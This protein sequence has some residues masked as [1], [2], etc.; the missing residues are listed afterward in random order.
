[1]TGPCPPRRRQVPAVGRI[2]RGAVE[3][4]Q[5]VA[6]DEV[7]EEVDPRGVR[8]GR[9]LAA[10]ADAAARGARGGAV[11][12]E[13]V[14][15]EPDHVAAGDAD[16]AP[17]IAVDGVADEPVGAALGVGGGDARAPGGADEPVD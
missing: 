12:G 1:Y 5:A 2:Q 8:A 15:D 16:A 10:D 7:R 14:V 6:A 17:A 11:A 3:L 13:G 9:V 4:P